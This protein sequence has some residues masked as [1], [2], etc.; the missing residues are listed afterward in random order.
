MNVRWLP[1][2]STMD[3]GMPEASKLNRLPSG[4]Q[5]AYV[6][7]PFRTRLSCNPLGGANALPPSVVN[8]YDA[9]SP[10]VKVTFPPPGK[11][12]RALKLW[13]VPSPKGPGVPDNLEL[14]DRTRARE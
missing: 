13:L 12:S 3:A 5:R 10:S 4:R 1:F 11:V 9:P 6:L 2:L 14:Y 8:A 7:S